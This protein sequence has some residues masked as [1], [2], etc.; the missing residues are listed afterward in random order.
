MNFSQRSFVYEVADYFPYG[1]EALR[2]IHYEYF[3]AP[4]LV[5]FVESFYDKA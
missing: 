4:A 5:D 2:S 1:K 3:A